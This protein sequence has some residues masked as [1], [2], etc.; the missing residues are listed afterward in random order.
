MERKAIVTIPPYAPYIDDVLNHE[1]VSGIRLNV[2]MPIKESEEEILK[3]LNDKSKRKE[4]DFWIDLKC[5]QLRVKNFAV[6]PYNEIQ[7][8]HKIDVFT[9]CKAYFSDRSEVATILE[10]NG[11]K[12][13]MQEGP[14]RI[15]GP[16]ESVTIPHPTLRIEGYLTNTDKRYIEAANKIGINNYMLSFV[17]NENDLEDLKKYN[18]N[19]NIVA[20]IESMKGLQYVKNQWNNNSRLMAAR[21]DLY[22]ELKWPHKITKS[23]EIILNKD[24]NAIAASRILP[25]LAESPEPSCSDIGDVDNLFRM[26]YKTLML[27]D[28]VCLKRNTVISALNVLKYMAEGYENN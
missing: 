4:K 16:G 10:V 23:L 12:L 5:R 22:M 17:E 2:V 11:D 7:L 21:G 1:F 8:S 26:G 24:N 13:I 28:E 27:G 15:V 6:A 14:K 3:K 19:A 20:K 9:P 18:G 25:S